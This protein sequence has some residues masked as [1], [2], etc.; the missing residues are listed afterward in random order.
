VELFPSSFGVYLVTDGGKLRVHG[1]LPEILLSLVSRFRSIIGVQI[2]ERL[3]DAEYPPASDE[4][5]CTLCSALR[6]NALRNDFKVVI[7]SEVE[8]CREI[9]ADGVHLGSGSM[10]P[11]EA[12]K[13]LGSE[14]LIGYS[15]HSVEEVL[16]SD[17]EV[18]DYVYLSPVF[19]PGSKKYTGELLGFA[20]LKKAAVADVSLFAL[21][22]VRPEHIEDIY[23]TG[24]S[25]VSVI[26]SILHADNPLQVMAEFDNKINSL[27]NTCQL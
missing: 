20:P 8:L 2:R 24:V 10:S 22:G 11:A 26:S 14:F 23:R 18:I 1:S 27:R 5:V 19:Q 16:A 7:N 21:G 17:P 6:K 12:R 25:G 3:L 13:I 15:A 9:G 4:Y